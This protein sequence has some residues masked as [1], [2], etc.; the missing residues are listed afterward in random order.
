MKFL[1]SLLVAAFCLSSVGLWAHGSTQHA[2]A[3][4]SAWARASAPGAPSAGFMVLHNHSNDDDILLSVSGDFAKKLEVHQSFEDNGIMRMEHQKKGV[5]IPA[6]GMVTFA[7][8]GYHL[9]FMGLS[10]NFEV[11]EAY[12]VTLTFEHAGDITVQ[13]EVMQGNNMSM[14]H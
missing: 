11:G 5:V 12:S 13:L 7:P 10:K 2:I 4:E 9:M 1:H 6:N 14:S 8:G 3:V